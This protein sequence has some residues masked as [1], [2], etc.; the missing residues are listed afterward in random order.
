MTATMIRCW[1]CAY[2]SRFVEQILHSIVVI[3]ASNSFV[4][5]FSHILYVLCGIEIRN[6]KDP[7]TEHKCLLERLWH[8]FRTPKQEEWKEYVR[9]VQTSN[10]SQWASFNSSLC[11]SFAILNLWHWSERTKTKPKKPRKTRDAQ[12]ASCCVWRYVH[13]CVES[14]AKCFLSAFSVRIPCHSVFVISE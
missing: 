14:K 9:S 13:E 2:N 6:A 1:V 10:L 11:R 3:W 8:V 5:I 4:H 7:F 12:H